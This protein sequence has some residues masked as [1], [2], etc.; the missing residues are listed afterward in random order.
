MNWRTHGAL[1]RPFMKQEEIFPFMRAMGGGT[2]WKCPLLP[3]GTLPLSK[4]RGHVERRRPLD[5]A[6]YLDRLSA[7][8]GNLAKT[9]GRAI[10]APLC[11]APRQGRAR[12]A[13]R[14][15]AARAQ[16]AVGAHKKPPAPKKPRAPAPKRK[17][18]WATVVET[19]WRT[20][21]RR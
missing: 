16:E 4:G 3:S 2:C 17:V 15:Q 18:K 19:L 7:L 20:F 1:V 5:P 8:M 10:D 21:W 14:A 11:P 12:G 9:S 6:G 13:G